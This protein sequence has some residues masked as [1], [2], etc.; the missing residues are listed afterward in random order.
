MI[1]AYSVGETSVLERPA[2]EESQGSGASALITRTLNLGPR[3]HRLFL[4]VAHQPGAAA[5]RLPVELP[6]SPLDRLVALVPSVP[7]EDRPTQGQ[8]AIAA[9]VIGG[10]TGMEWV[11]SEQGHAEQ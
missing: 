10:P 3:T 1:L 5:Q 2:C 11:V 6:E 7:N 4:Q 9:A 8:G